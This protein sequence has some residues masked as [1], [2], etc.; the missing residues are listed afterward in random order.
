MEHME[1]TLDDYELTNEIHAEVKLEVE[2]DWEPYN[3]GRWEDEP[4]SGGGPDC[5]EVK[6]ISAKLYDSEGRESV[7]DEAT[8][9]LLQ[10][11]LD[12]DSKM[13]EWIGEQLQ[14][15]GEPDNEPDYDPPW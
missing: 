7:A 1:L 2:Y 8:L 12:K 13:S 14:E 6:V 5:W 11:K 10:E 9:K 15:K 4:P 3:P